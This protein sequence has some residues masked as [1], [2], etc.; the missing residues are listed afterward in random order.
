LPPDRR[1]LITGASGLFADYLVEAC[2]GQGQITT[3]ARSEGDRRCDLSD[4]TSTGSLL[5]VVAPDIVIHAAG[6]TD[7]D[8]CQ[9]EPHAA[10][11]ANRDTVANLA[12]M[13]APTTRL[14]CIST[15]QVYPDTPGPH[16]E[17]RT[18]PLNFYGS[19]KLKGEQAALSHPRALILR[20]NFFGH[21]RRVGRESLSDFV[22]NSVTTHKPVTFFSDV[23]FSPLHMSTLA[24]LIV[25]LVNKGATG[26]FNAGSRAGQ[27]KADFALA[28][29]R[30]KGLTTETVGV[31]SSSEVRGRAPRIHD[32]RLNVS[33]IE[34]FLGRAMPTLEEEIRKL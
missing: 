16:D 11:A 17:N 14:V 2:R 3:T 5:S 20:T 12:S 15:D 22:I 9:R 24:S 30:H 18:G 13:L 34:R 8:L 29:A 19:S 31:G 4:A 10:Y 25:E 1:W 7:V 26:V 6:L 28:I 32:L 21:S 27:S 23:L 33:R